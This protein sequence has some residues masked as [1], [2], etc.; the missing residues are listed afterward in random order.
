MHRASLVHDSLLNAMCLNGNE[1]LAAGGLTQLTPAPL[2]SGSTNNTCEDGF[3]SEA[4]GKGMQE[5]DKKA[6]EFYEVWCEGRGSLI[7]ELIPL[8][9]LIRS[10]NQYFLSICYVSYM[11]QGCGNAVEAVAGEGDNI[12]RGPT[13][14]QTML[15][16]LH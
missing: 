14:C 4:E 15:R 3:G 12:P 7:W 9:L 1:R 6:S 10:S 8:V 16:A 2:W 13:V 11:V 5:S